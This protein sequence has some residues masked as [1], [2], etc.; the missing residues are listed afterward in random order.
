MAPGFVYV[1]VGTLF[2][3]SP[4]VLLFMYQTTTD[5]QQALNNRLNLLRGPSGPTGGP[6]DV[7]NG[8]AFNASDCSG[9][10]PP[11][12]NCT[13]GS[14]YLC[15]DVNQF[16]VCDSSGSWVLAVNVASASGHTGPTGSS[17]VAGTS[18]GMGANGA[19]G[20]SGTTGPSGDSGGQG[21]SGPYGPDGET[22]SPGP[23]GSTGALGASGL[24]G[25][26]GFTGVSGPTGGR[27][28]DINVAKTVQVGWTGD[29]GCPTISSSTDLVAFTLYFSPVTYCGGW[30]SGFLKYSF[31][32][33]T[34][35]P[36]LN[37]WV[38]L[39]GSVASSGQRDGASTAYSF[40]GFIWYY[41]ALNNMNITN[42]EFLIWD[43]GY[44]LGGGGTA[45]GNSIL[46]TSTDGI[47]FAQINTNLPSLSISYTFTAVF[48]NNEGKWLMPVNGPG[49]NHSILAASSLTP[50][51]WSVV[52]TFASTQLNSVCYSAEMSLWMVVGNGYISIAPTFSGP[53][54]PFT[55]VDVPLYDWK[56]CAYGHGLFL[57]I[58]NG[59]L[60][61]VWR[62]IAGTTTL[63]DYTLSSSSALT[64]IAFSNDF[65]M[66][67]VT[68]TNPFN[69]LAFL[70]YFSSD[71][72][73][74]TW[75]NRL[76]PGLNRATAFVRSA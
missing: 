55:G 11:N 46:W 59:P 5:N 62:N 34:Y 18:G 49:T 52:L 19:S 24:S 58:G 42:P 66:W 56:G 32:D 68:Y 1:L 33:I 73:A 44:F 30:P 23:S 6:G 3:L 2:V 27:P 63:L 71:Y 76:A 25:S 12:V 39:L 9:G 43:A 51:T 75:V 38:A 70:T 13:L 22:G 48:S 28:N 7:L 61:A 15:F 4:F 64:D 53:F 20:A 54:T 50:D 37:M 16:Y 36:V 74:T 72:N 21:V 35:N 41:S 26:S 29:T 65:Q 69:L 60:G 40:D 31:L 47:N 10:P 8:P 45:N 14:V 57:I 17:G 67:S